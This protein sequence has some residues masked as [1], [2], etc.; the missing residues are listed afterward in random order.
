MKN[1]LKTIQVTKNNAKQ[2]KK[3]KLYHFFE[4]YEDTKGA[5]EQNSRAHDEERRTRR[6]HVVIA[7]NL[8]EEEIIGLMEM[9]KSMDTDNSRTITFEEL[10]VGLPKLATPCGDSAIKRGET[11]PVYFISKVLQDAERRYQR[12]EKATLTLVITSQRLCPYFHGYPMIIWIDLPIKQVL[13]K[14]NLV[15]QM[16]T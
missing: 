6:R 14:P 10:E 15:G 1:I 12:I 4:E 2:Y 9:F 3:S 11:T 7:D 16:V 8:S 13:R 5:D